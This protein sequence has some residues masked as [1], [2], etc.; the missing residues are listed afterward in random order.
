VKLRFGYVSRNLTMTPV[1][2]RISS[3]VAAIVAATL[4]YGCASTPSAKEEQSPAPS[5]LSGMAGR[6]LLVLPAQYLATPTP[7]GGWDIVPSGPQLLPILDQEI[8][9]VFRKRG[10]RSN[11]TFGSEITESARRNGGLAGDP[12][13]LSVQGIRRVK[14]GDTPLPEPLA[15]EIRGLVAL[16]SARYAVVPLEIHV[17]VRGI[18]RRG[19]ARMLLIDARTARVVWAEDI[20]ATTVRDAQAAS[21]ALTPYGFRLLARDLASKFADMVVAQ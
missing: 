13:Q 15:S 19:S 21:E 7:G 2:S 6:Q 8:A 9:D 4:L 11:W 10:V 3:S 20:E 14:A 5:L 12:R 16:T 17:D 1:R 18:E